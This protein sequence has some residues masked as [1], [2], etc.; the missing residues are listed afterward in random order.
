MTHCQSLRQ[1]QQRSGEC[2]PDRKTKASHRPGIE[3]AIRSARR[4]QIGR[5]ADRQ[6]ALGRAR[7]GAQ[8]DAALT[9]PILNELSLGAVSKRVRNYHF[10]PR[11]GPLPDSSGATAD[12]HTPP[13]ATH[14]ALERLL[15]RDSRRCDG[16]APSSA[17]APPCGREAHSSRVPTLCS[18]IAVLPP[19]SRW[20]L[21]THRP[22]SAK[23]GRERAARRL[24][25]SS[26]RA[27][28]CGRG[29]QPGPRA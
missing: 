14:S 1:P 21:L 8:V 3:R 23:A 13:Q 29:D 18:V 25:C 2:L 20:A 22:A 26:C 17:R 11:V 10:P 7:I 6:T 5:H 12:P 19:L 9:V 24:A 16:S 28:V 4:A 15:A 27:S